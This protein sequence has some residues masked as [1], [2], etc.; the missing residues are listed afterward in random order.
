MHLS[1]NI[2]DPFRVYLV[3]DLYNLYKGNNK[4]DYSK[5]HLTLLT[6][7]VFTHEDLQIYMNK[8]LVHCSSNEL[9]LL[10]VLVCAKLNVTTLFQNNGNPIKLYHDLVDVSTV[11]HCFIE[12]LYNNSENMEMSYLD[13]RKY[14]KKIHQTGTLEVLDYMFL[15]KVGDR[16]ISPYVKYKAEDFRQVH[17]EVPNYEA[18]REELWNNRN[19]PY[20]YHEV[21][22]P[23]RIYTSRMCIKRRPFKESEEFPIIKEDNSTM[24]LRDLVFGDFLNENWWFKRPYSYM[25]KNSVYLETHDLINLFFKDV[26]ELTKSDLMRVENI[27]YTNSEWHEAR[28]RFQRNIR[29]PKFKKLNDIYNSLS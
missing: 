20:P 27:L 23:G 10:M 5:D 26:N 17:Y 7:S 12:S 22:A 6:N 19:R 28:H 14:L 8:P 25:N 21:G 18:I 11:L 4:V 1:I 2:I 15:P 16:F 9:K 13:H 3:K 24:R 29:L